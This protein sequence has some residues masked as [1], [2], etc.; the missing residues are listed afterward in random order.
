MS[1][2]RK[3][4]MKELQLRNLSPITSDTYIRSIARFRQ[5]F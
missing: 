5:V 4:M 3:R 1:P 2:L